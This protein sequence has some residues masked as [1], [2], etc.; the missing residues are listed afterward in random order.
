MNRSRPAGIQVRKTRPQNIGRTCVPNATVMKILK[1]KWKVTGDA[2]SWLV[3]LFLMAQASGSTTRILQSWTPLLHTVKG[4]ALSR[5]SGPQLHPALKTV[6]SQSL[7]FELLQLNL[8]S[9]LPQQFFFP[10]LGDCHVLCGWPGGPGPG[11]LRHSLPSILDQSL[12]PQ[13][14]GLGWLR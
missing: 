9:L 5:G 11:G 4:E 3:N 6:L 10:S 14:R 12:S 1:Y 7:L 2:C 13:T 8:C